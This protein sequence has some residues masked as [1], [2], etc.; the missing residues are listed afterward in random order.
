MSTSIKIIRNRI[1]IVREELHAKAAA[2]VRKAILRTEV[3]I[4]K[5]MASAKHGRLYRVSKTGKPHQASAPGEAP[6]M[7]T[8]ALANSIHTEMIGPLTGIVYTNQEYAAA[9]EFGFARLAAR[10]F[11]RPAVEIVA[12]Q[13]IQA[14][15]RI[16]K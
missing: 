8:G 16:L 7:D 5:S 1:P 15:E 10:P 4:K 13:F 2:E 12:P 6:A 9:L 14:M 3:E 11:M